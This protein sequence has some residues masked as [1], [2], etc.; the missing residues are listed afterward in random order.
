VIMVCVPARVRTVHVGPDWLTMT[1]R[2]MVRAP[3]DVPPPV[4]VGTGAGEVATVTAGAALTAVHVESPDAA[5]VTPNQTAAVATAMAPAIAAMDVACRRSQGL[6]DVGRLGGGG[7]NGIGSV[8]WVTGPP[9]GRRMHVVPSKC[10]GLVWS[11]CGEH[12]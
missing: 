4:G 12:R 10:Q 3:A 11:R 1:A 9:S 7:T 8:G 2:T 6:R 5:A